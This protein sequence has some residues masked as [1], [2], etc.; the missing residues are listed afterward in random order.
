MIY[1]YKTQDIASCKTLCCPLMYGLRRPVF[2]IRP[3]G[4]IFSSVDSLACRLSVSN[5]KFSQ[6][7]ISYI[8]CAK[9][10]GDESCCARI[11][12]LITQWMNIPNLFCKRCDCFVHYSSKIL[13]SFAICLIFC[14]IRLTNCLVV[15]LHFKI[16]GK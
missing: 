16:R 13:Y 7:R 4:T 3:C 15:F 8:S 5:V 2:R 14:F 12:A 11:C 9:R 10:Q 6:F 1:A